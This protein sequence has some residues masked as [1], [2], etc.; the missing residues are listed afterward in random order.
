MT[1]AAPQDEIWEKIA[2]NMLRA[3]MMRRGISYARLTEQ[4]RS[5]GIEDNEA[6]VRN[7]VGRGRFTAIFF[8][9]CMTAIGADWLRIPSAEEIAVAAGEYGAQALATGVP[10]S[11]GPPPS[12]TRG[13]RS[14]S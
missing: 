14:K 2:R 1:S 12:R 8:F 3:E 11:E 6:N 4:L 9:Q 13:G 7:K 5:L 10:I